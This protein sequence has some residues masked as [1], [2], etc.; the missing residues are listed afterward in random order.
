MKI[1]IL[2]NQQDSDKA[3]GTYVT[4][5]I[6]KDAAQTAMREDWEKSIKDWKID[7][8]KPATD[9]CYYECN[10]DSA[11]ICDDGMERWTIEE[12]EIDVKVAVEV[13]GGLVSNVYA[14]ADLGVEVYDLDVSD[15]PD[16]GEQETADA[17]AKELADLINSP[18]WERVW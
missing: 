12:H 18:E 16:E 6:S 7:V 15:F 14:N 2:I 4:P 9:D 3:F 1:F 5:F 8:S 11:V 17:K 10:A 13:S